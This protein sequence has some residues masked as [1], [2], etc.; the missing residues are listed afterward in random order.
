MIMFGKSVGKLLAK[1]Q[2]LSAQLA[3]LLTGADKAVEH[4]AAALSTIASEIHTLEALK[5][6]L[7]TGGG[8]A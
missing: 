6:R 5:A 1:E 3:K 2:E 8:N 7:A 4:R